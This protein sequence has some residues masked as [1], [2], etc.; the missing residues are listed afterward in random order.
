MSCCGHN[1]AT[2]R[3][4][5]LFANSSRKR[6]EKKGFEDSQKHLLEGLKQAGYV[7]ASVLEIGSGAGN[8]HQ[9]LLQQGASSATGV[10]LA[11]KMITEAK[12]W[13]HDRQLDSQ[14]DY[15]QGDFV[16]LAET[17]APSGVTVL[18]KVVCCYP[19]ADALVHKSLAKTQRVYA[20]TY[21]RYTRLNRFLSKVMAAIFWTIRF[22]FRNFVHNPKQIEDWI[23]AA[24]FRRLYQNQTRI[25]LT[26]VYVRD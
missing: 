7:G 3:F 16:E 8:L 9:T 19:D 12:R 26:E 4:F 15:R 14:V 1:R 20:L 11:P 22:D 6:F 10:D 25:W 5:S 17:I 23:E 13:A 21:P 2:G 24:G 18:D